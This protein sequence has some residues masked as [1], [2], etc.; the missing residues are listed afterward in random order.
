MFT[1]SAEILTF[2]KSGPA[3][4]GTGVEFVSGTPLLPPAQVDGPAT[5]WAPNRA[6]KVLGC[7]LDVC[8]V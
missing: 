5:R 1:A 2:G 7:E 4:P 6:S 8:C 3:A